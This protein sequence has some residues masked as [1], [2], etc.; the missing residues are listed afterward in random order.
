MLLFGGGTLLFMVLLYHMRAILNP[1]VLAGACIILFWP[2]RHHKI[3]HAMLLSGGFLLLVWFL[4]SLSGVLLPFVSVYLLAYL[5]DPVVSYLHQRYRVPRGVSSLFVTLLIVGVVALL[6]LFLVPHI[7]SQLGTLGAH[8]VSSLRE[9]REWLLGSP[10]LEYAAPTDG[11]KEALIDRFTN[12]MQEYVRTWTASIPS[13]MEDML[14]SLGPVFGVLVIAVVMPVS[15]FYMLKDYRIIKRGLIAL[16]PL[17]GGQRTYLKK[18]SGIV[19]NYLR[20]QLMISAV[21]AVTV[22]A[23]LMIAGVPFAVLIGLLAGLLNMIPNLG[24][25]L[26]NAIGICIALVFGERG[27]LD[28]VLVVTILLGQSLLEQ[29][30]LIPKILSHHVGLHP[31]L[32]LLSLFIF[33][34][35]LGVIGLFVAVP[36]MALIATVYQ[37]YRSQMTFDLSTYAEPHAY[38]GYQNPSV[39]EG[40]TQRQEHEQK[41]QSILNA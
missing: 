8:V 38:R 36:A 41:E 2:I 29:A 12:P 24:A 17:V 22:S 26:T 31:I 6:A 34:A 15:L 14:E 9:L 19:G 13:N 23:A 11:E 7:L 16:L 27:L 37:T 30:V 39:P 1:A 21:G 10:L 18:V 3:A 4:V 35:F 20:G 28:V 40:V 33:G 32:I 5:F 25:I